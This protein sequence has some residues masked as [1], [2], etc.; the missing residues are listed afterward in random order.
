MSTTGGCALGASNYGNKSPLFLYY[1]HT[2]S[3]HSPQPKKLHIPTQ[4]AN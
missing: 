1:H 4:R 2:T 3:L